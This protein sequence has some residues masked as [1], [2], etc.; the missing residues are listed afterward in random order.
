MRL[1]SLNIDP[2]VDSNHIIFT[3][4]TGLFKH[5]ATLLKWVFL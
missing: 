5:S 2:V 3:T 1:P 4:G